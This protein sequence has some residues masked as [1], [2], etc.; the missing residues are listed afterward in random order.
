[1]TP[2]YGWTQKGERLVDHTPHNHWLTVTGVFGLTL[3]GLVAP[4][5]FTGGM[6]NALFVEYIKKHII[7]LVSDGYTVICDNLAPHKQK[8]IGEMLEAR[9]AKLL[10]LPAYSP[11]L[12]PIE[13]SFS[14]IKTLLRKEKLRTVDQVN[15][16]FQNAPAFITPEDSQGYFFHSLRVANNL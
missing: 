3:N 9:G 14:K 1:M 2:L 11:D 15:D 6:T 10:L 13:M 8:I 7:P 4:F 12:N 5:T 16:F